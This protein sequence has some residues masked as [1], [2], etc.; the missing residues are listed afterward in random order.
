MLAGLIERGRKISGVELARLEVR[1]AALSGGLNK[2]LAS[3]D[4]LLMR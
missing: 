1:R 4:L 3:I 2:L